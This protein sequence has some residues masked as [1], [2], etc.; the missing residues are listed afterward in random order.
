MG[1]SKL[2]VQFNNIGM[3]CVCSWVSFSLIWLVMSLFS[4]SE[5]IMTQKMLKHNSIN[6]FLRYWSIFCSFHPLCSKQLYSSFQSTIYIYI[7]LVLICFFCKIFYLLC[8]L[9]CTTLQRKNEFIVLNIDIHLG[10]NQSTVT[11]SHS[12]WRMFFSVDL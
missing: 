6:K 2:I 8:L 11:E 10:K 1:A 3:K 5:S 4:S 12:L 7:I 9:S